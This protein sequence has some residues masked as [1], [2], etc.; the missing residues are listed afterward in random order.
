MIRAF[1]FLNLPRS[2]H[3]SCAFLA[4]RR[5][6]RN[7]PN[8]GIS[9]QMKILDSGAT[10]SRYQPNDDDY[11]YSQLESDFQNVDATHR[12]YERDHTK[13]QERVKHM[14][15]R[16]KYFR[17]VPQPNFL[18]WSE[19][20]QIRHL[21]R[22][23]PV[24]WS[25]DKLAE[26]FPADA[27]TIAKILRATWQPRTDTRVR[28]HD[29]SVRLA[30]ERFTIE[31][32]EV[33]DQMHPQLREHLTKFSNRNIVTRSERPVV[34]EKRILIGK[35]K[36]TSEFEDIIS[37]SCGGQKYVKS[38]E[39]STPQLA[40]VQDRMRRA[41]STDD[42]SFFL[43]KIDRSKPL[44]FKELAMTS[45]T[46][47]NRSEPLHN[48]FQ[49]PDELRPKAAAVFAEPAAETGPIQKYLST[50]VQSTEADLKKL[51][52]APILDQITIPKR[53]Y[54]EGATYKINDCYYD[55]DG[56]FLYRVPGM[57]GHK[58]S[59]N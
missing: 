36:K 47:M 33:V 13:Y 1:V 8:A 51:S 56:E 25:A 32:R 54:R 4:R 40:A 48:P 26:C 57:S 41:P 5:N 9:K 16:R 37:S 58:N 7:L 21:N 44:M 53:L 59:S 50:E 18:T 31:D 55:D 28:K 27:L 15:V 49:D 35:E 10:T 17:T 52:M 30:W 39:S 45:E 24:E 2:V 43:G 6:V 38:D 3:T 14:T 23:D 11:D 29:E 19:K 20:E 34:V 12:L 46:S 42:D 22:T